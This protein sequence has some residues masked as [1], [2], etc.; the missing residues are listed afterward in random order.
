[1]SERADA[2][3]NRAEA[4]GTWLY[5]QRTEPDKRIAEV[6]SEKSIRLG[7]DRIRLLERQGMKYPQRYF[8]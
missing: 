5:E 6:Q 8:P 7:C 3:R 2:E 4:C 1:M